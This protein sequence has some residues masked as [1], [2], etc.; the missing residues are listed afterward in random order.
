MQYCGTEMLLSSWPSDLFGSAMRTVCWMEFS[1]G[2]ELSYF[3]LL[4]T[5][6]MIPMYGQT[7]NSSTQRGT[8][9]LLSQPHRYCTNL[10]S[11]IWAGCPD[12]MQSVIGYQ[13]NQAN[14]MSLFLLDLQYTQFCFQTVY[15]RFGVCGEGG[16]LESATGHDLTGF[17]VVWNAGFKKSSRKIGTSV[18]NSCCVFT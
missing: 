17:A 18:F 3:C 9:N 10:Y 13:Y 15:R 6:I 16:L 5:F 4:I 8:V 14:V 2:R 7:Q 1:S 12:R 11:S